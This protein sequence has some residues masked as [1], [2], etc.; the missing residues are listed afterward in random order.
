MFL[1]NYVVG[2]CFY[3]FTAT[4]NLYFLFLKKLFDILHLFKIPTR[5]HRINLN[6]YAYCQY[7]VFF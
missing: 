1:F 7:E 5:K 2:I 4:F 6:N 3:M